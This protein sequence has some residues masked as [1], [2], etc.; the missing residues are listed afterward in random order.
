[1]SLEARLV[2]T[3]YVRLPAARRA[4]A[5][6]DAQDAVT[7]KSRLNVLPR[8]LSVWHFDREGRPRAATI[9]HLHYDANPPYYTITFDETAEEAPRE[10]VRERLVP[11]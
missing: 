11:M 6:K 10:T 5:A 4:V 3:G 2:D 1:M 7:D 8:G 9:S